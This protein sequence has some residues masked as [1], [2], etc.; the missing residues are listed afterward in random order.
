MRFSFFESFLPLFPS[1]FLSETSYST[2]PSVSVS[3]RSN[4]IN[5]CC[6][7]V[8]F[9]SIFPLLFIYDPAIS[10][11]WE[12]ELTIWNHTV[13]MQYDTWFSI[14]VTFCHRRSVCMIIIRGR[15]QPWFVELC[16]SMSSWFWNI[17]HTIAMYL[18]TNKMIT[19]SKEPMLRWMLCNL[20]SHL[21]TWLTQLTKLMWHNAEP[22]GS[23]KICKSHFMVSCKICIFFPIVRLVYISEV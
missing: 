10:L 1:Y 13:A 23:R 8:I 16:P 5:L 17:N 21:L 22:Q 19:A 9:Y 12:P 18:S 20:P 6:T 2:L 3:L 11:I 4:H 7:C 14:P 15:V